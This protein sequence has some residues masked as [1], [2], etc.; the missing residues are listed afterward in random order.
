VCHEYRTSR[1]FEGV[2][3]SIAQ[4]S[5]DDHSSCLAYRTPSMLRAHTGNSI[6]SDE[7]I[8]SHAASRGV[9]P[10]PTSQ[11]RFA[12]TVRFDG[13]HK[14]VHPRHK[15]KHPS[16][17]Q[18]I[19]GSDGAR[20]LRAASSAVRPLVITIDSGCTFHMHLNRDDLVNVRPCSDTITGLTE[21]VKC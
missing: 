5:S 4:L 3:S 20:R 1:V 2:P 17:L 19:A 21:T 18:H 9:E 8:L 10:P 6:P 15:R 12:N 11:V 13:K 16:W 7:V 14:R